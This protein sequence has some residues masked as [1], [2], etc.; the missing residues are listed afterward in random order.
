M[1]E[2]LPTLRRRHRQRFCLTFGVSMANAVLPEVFTIRDVARA[3]GVPQRS[4]QALVDSGLVATLPVGGARVYLDYEEAVRVGRAMA[5]GESTARPAGD[6][7]PLFRRAVDRPRARVPFALSTV[8]H[9]AII[10]VVT[11]GTFA[12]GA[13]AP[14]SANRARQQ[15]HLVY[16]TVPGPGGGGGGGG[17]GRP[18]PAPR[19]RR[20]GK[21][22]LSSPIPSRTL[23]TTPA[24]RAPEPK[25]QVEPVKAPVVEVP[26][27]AEER[28]GVVEETPAPEDS[29]GP[30]DDGSA[31]AGNG[32]GIGEGSG[33]GVGPGEEQGV[34]GGPYR[35]GSGI[36]P[37]TVMREVKPLYT[38]PAR[39]R[40]LQGDVLLEIVVRRDGSVGDVRIVKGL[41]EGLDQKA[42]DAVRQWKFNPARRHGT[43]VDVLVEVAMEFRLR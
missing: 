10:S 30:G 29:R 35:P 42:V 13:A 25:P 22:P 5:R 2:F 18:E 37:P 14:Q 8:A 12:M 3:A 15:T 33:K 41:G 24:P 19:A 28:P 16:L 38:E 7:A 11:F 43:P 17:E 27:D 31:G 40:G 26:A 21:R 32:G 9:V 34:G 23:P 20:P 1:V 36:E 39:R 4:I 6:L